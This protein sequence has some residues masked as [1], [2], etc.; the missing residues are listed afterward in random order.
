MVDKFEMYK[1]FL[2]KIQLKN[3]DIK[4]LD[5]FHKK[6]NAKKNVFLLV[7]FLSK[8]L[9][10]AKKVS[11]TFLPTWGHSSHHSKKKK[12]DSSQLCQYSPV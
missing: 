2:I 12:K 7:V 4:T 6:N 8:I 3:C 1:L 11:V 5:L 10:K 9:G